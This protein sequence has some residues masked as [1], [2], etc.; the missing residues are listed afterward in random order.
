MKSLGGFSKTEL[1]EKITVQEVKS[2]QLINI[3]MAA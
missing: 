2:F 1:H 3:A